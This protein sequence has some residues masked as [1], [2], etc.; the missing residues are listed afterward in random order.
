MI[1]QSILK[2]V[3]HLITKGDFGLE[4][5]NL[6]V[7]KNG[8][9]ALTQHPSIFGDK[10]ENQF[11]TTDFS[12]SQIELITPPLPSIEEMY[13]F[14]HTLHDVVSNE[15]GDELLWTQSLPPILPDESLIPIAKYQN[16]SKE[17]EDYRNT[18]AEVYGKHR[19]MI[20][21]VHFN[22]SLVD[23]LFVA[24]QKELGN[25]I[26]IGDIKE[27]V[28]LKITRGLMRYRWILV[29]M[30]GESPIAEPNFKVMSLTTHE[31]QFMSCKAGMAL[32]VGPLGYRNKDNYIMNFDSIEEYQ[33]II[34]KLVSKGELHSAKE[35]YLPIRMKF[36][37]RDKG[38]PTYLEVRFL[39]LDPLSPT[40][41]DKDALYATYMLF[42]YSLLC[43]EDVAFD[44]TEQ[45]NATLRQDISSCYGRCS[46]ASFPAKISNGKTI[47]EEAHS[48]IQ[49]MRSVLSEFGVT[50]NPIYAA[51]LDKMEQL[52][53][54]PTMRKG[55][56]LAE[57]SKKH[58]FI[59]Y[60]LNLAKKYKKDAELSGYRF[61]GAETMEMST[62]LLMRAALCK[63]VG[64]EILDQSEN[65]IRLSKENNSQ[66][67]I[68][69]TKTAIDNYATVLAMGN[70][71]VTKKLLSESGVMVP[72][73]GE[74]FTKQEALNS[75]SSYKNRAIVIK[76]K[77]TNF[78]IGI[79]ILKDNSNIA[80]FEKALN[81][82]FGHDNCVLIENF[83]E[84]RE[85][86]IFVIDNEVVG[87]LHRVPANVEG[88]GTRTVRELVELKNQDPRRGKG[89]RTP[90]EKIALGEE[91]SLFLE[92]QGAT[93][94][95]VVKSGEKLY[96][97]E[98]SN[99]S[100]GG[101]SIDF[102]DDIDVSY[103]TIAV[104]AAQ[105]VNAR[106]TG[107][108]MM[109]KDIK[110]AA[111]ETNYSIIEINFNPAIHIHCFPY[112]GKNRRLNF[113]ILKALGFE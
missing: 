85:F 9:L 29:W 25:S 45:Y 10:S 98:N 7:D 43:E 102:T 103:K 38:K 100:T 73:G 63:G 8:K 95:T 50:E 62:Q 84:G 107:V 99:I 20:C 27:E 36:L 16:S 90:L 65:F 105:A 17:L 14:M 6:R 61:W 75:F 31:E 24:L 88:D 113:K 32:R 48:F 2:K 1:T 108:D 96:L 112:K 26:P 109:I 22:I 53:I 33:N 59:E 19:Q 35:L 72:A 76:P 70:K 79:T 89:Y 30:F 5:E 81:I 28:Y 106:I 86:R 64:I 101:D 60:Y 91:E 69:A 67:V 13:N 55:V 94:E 77:S 78:G 74:Y 12:E 11:I 57:Q 40:G 23:E 41:I 66:L 54:K 80:N 18:I 71:V 93:F 83:V 47:A 87:V 68:Q 49:K 4:K 44:E 56:I 51:T 34:D 58:G 92:L 97:R 52:A 15:L 110:E 82:A 39:D 37:D 3:S 46:N 104:R 42:L 111:S 21:G